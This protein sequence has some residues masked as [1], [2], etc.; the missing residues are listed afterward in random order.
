VLASDIDRR[1]LTIARENVRLNR[2][3]PYV[4]VIQAGGVGAGR[5]RRRAPFE[6]IF[7]NILLEPLQRMA[8]PLARLTAPGGHVVLSG[9]LLSQAGP[10]LASYRARGLVLVRRIRLEGWATLVL[11]R[12]CRKQRRLPPRRPVP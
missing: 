11:A 10:A 1:A 7:A 4:E 6:L 5:F 9:L 8:T 3:A 12:P 2:V